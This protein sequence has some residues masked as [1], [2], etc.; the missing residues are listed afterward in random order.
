MCKN[1]DCPSQVVKKLANGIEALEIKGIGEGK[2][3]MLVESGITS[4]FDFFNPNKMNEAFLSKGQFKRGRELDLVLECPKKITEVD[5]DR[6]ILSLQ[7][8]N[9]GKS[10]SLEAAKIL[11][12]NKP[13][14]NNTKKVLDQFMDAGNGSVLMVRSLVTL[15]QA[16]GIKVNGPKDTTGTMGVEMTGSPDGSGYKTKDELLK[17]LATKGYAHTGLKDAKILLTDSHTSTSSKMAAARKKG[18]QIMTY[19]ELIAS[20]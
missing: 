13:I 18:I 11:T 17:F 4:I 5:L 6:V 16:N 7:F 14:L 19:Q 8:L 12:S 15:L 9:L 10:G 3:L 1:T 20:L 2:A